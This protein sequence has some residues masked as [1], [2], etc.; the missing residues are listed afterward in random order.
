MGLEITNKLTYTTKRQ[1]N[2]FDKVK[3]TNLFKFSNA[4][5]H[6]ASSKAFEPE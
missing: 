1:G 5:H 3:H 2:H 4:G 6:T